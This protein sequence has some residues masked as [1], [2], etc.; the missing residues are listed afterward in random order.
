MTREQLAHVLS[1]VSRIVKTSDV[2]VYGS[3]SIL[4]S[5]SQDGKHSA[6]SRCVISYRAA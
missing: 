6:Q 1:L 5:Y 2:L 3:Q 4:G